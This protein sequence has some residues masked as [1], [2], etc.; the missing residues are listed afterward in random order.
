MLDFSFGWVYNIFCLIAAHLAQLVEH[1]R[2]MEGVGGS[3]PSVSTMISQQ[4]VFACCFFCYEKLVVVN[5]TCKGSDGHRV[6]HCFAR[7]LYKEAVQYGNQ[8]EGIWPL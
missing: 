8:Y 2:H 6:K 3:S 7:S 5:Q 1:L 4:C